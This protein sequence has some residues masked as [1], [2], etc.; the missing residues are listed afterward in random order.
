MGCSTW[1]YKYLGK[2]I[3]IAEKSREDVV[4][5]RNNRA[6]LSSKMHSKKMKLSQDAAKEIPH[7]R[8]SKCRNRLPT[9]SAIRE[10]QNSSGKVP[11]LTW[12]EDKL[13]DLQRFLPA[14]MILSH[15]L[16]LPIEESQLML[17]HFICICLKLDLNVNTWK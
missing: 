3:Y 9:G 2:L 5:A 17:H 14:L 15:N 1:T 11:A 10:T 12:K 6:R 7:W 13:R 8:G 16:T 4:I